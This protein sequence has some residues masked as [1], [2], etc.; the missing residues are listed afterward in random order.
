MDIVMPLFK[1]LILNNGMCK[2]KNIYRKIAN[3]VPQQEN[4]ND[5]G[6]FLCKF[7]QYLINEKKFDF[8]STDVAYF[9]LL[10]GVEIILGRSLSE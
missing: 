6:V 2:N 7:I 8:D 1:D 4:L 3:D 5:C 9:R 10:I